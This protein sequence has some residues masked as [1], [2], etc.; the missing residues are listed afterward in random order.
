MQ[1]NYYCYGVPLHTNPPLKVCNIS[2]L[3]LV[4]HQQHTVIA[5]ISTN[6]GICTLLSFSLH[7][8]PQDYAI[9]STYAPNPFVF[10][11]QTPRFCLELCNISLLSWP[12]T[13]WCCVLFTQHLVIIFNKYKI[14]PYTLCSFLLSVPHVCYSLTYSVMYVVSL[15]TS[16]ILP[17]ILPFLSHQQA[18][19]YTLL[20]YNVL[21]GLSLPVSKCV[22]G[23]LCTVSYQQTH[24]Q[25]KVMARLLCVCSS[26]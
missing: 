2:L 21:Y 24:D 16:S 1:A 13:K 23:L 25:R 15:P 20:Q 17:R 12:T 3:C 9:N 7:R 6:I 22:V 14:M 10:P 18:Q 4:F 26:H 19:Y 5:A 8:Q 11:N